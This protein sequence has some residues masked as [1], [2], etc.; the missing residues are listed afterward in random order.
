MGESFVIKNISRLVTMTETKGIKGKLGVVSGAALRIRGGR[1]AWLGLQKKLPKVQSHENEID[2]AG[3]VVLPGFVDCH[4]HLIH[5]GFRQNEFKMRSEGKTYQEIAKAGG[6]IMSSVRN[7]R[8][9]SAEIL[10]ECGIVRAF[11]AISNGT[12][13]IEIKSGYGLDAKTEAKII[14]VI[15]ALKSKCPAHIFGTT[16]AAHLIPAEFKRR[17]NSYMSLVLNK[18]LPLAAASGHISGCDVFV[19]AGAFT[20]DE[21]RKIAKKAK[22]F[23]LLMH[24]HVDQFV[25]DGGA[26]LAAE[27]KAI[28]ADHLDYSSERG[29]KALVRAG[30]VAVILPGASFFAGRGHYPDAKKMIRTGIRV[31]IA[32][33]YN[34]GTN[35]NLDLLLSATIAVTQMGLSCDDALLGITKNAALA[36]GCEDRGVIKVGAMADLVFLDVPDE[37]FALYRYGAH[38]VAKTIIEGEVVFDN[39]RGF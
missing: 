15:G 36:L 21:A 18:M 6:G 17:R 33:D 14:K 37:Y 32:T 29:I 38:S 13:T 5:A 39:Q 9:A 34:P 16:L 23:G 20:P 25:D 27:L 1:I 7:T 8:A 26:A 24:M 31:A 12:T 19:D 22:E 11:E 4:T 28:S 30:T 35:P 3:M 2:A 10:L